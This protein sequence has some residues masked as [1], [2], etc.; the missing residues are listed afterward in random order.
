MTDILHHPCKTLEAAVCKKSKHCI[1]VLSNALNSL[2]IS[3]VQKC[4][5]IWANETFGFSNKHTNYNMKL[6]IQITKVSLFSGVC[7]LKNK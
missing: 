3:V 5:I 4:Y 7:L 1:V 6:R 2:G